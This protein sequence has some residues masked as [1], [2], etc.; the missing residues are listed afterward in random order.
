MPSCHLKG[1]SP[2]SHPEWQEKVREVPVAGAEGQVPGSL[3]P[4]QS[5]WGAGGGEQQREV[6][7]F[8]AGEQSRGR[9]ET[10]SG[11]QG[12]GGGVQCGQGRGLQGRAARGRLLSFTGWGRA[13][14]AL[15]QAS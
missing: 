8:P 7:S 13:G 6:G 5:L 1:T 3:V 2:R 4:D 12:Q 10:L 14:R 11:G 9:R 15:L